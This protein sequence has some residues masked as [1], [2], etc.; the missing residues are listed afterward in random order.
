MPHAPP[1]AAR[2]PRAS[3]VETTNSTAGPGVKHSTVSSTTNA[4]QTCSVMRRRRV[5][6]SL[7]AAVERH[8]PNRR[9]VHV[10]ET[11]NI[12]SGRL[13]TVR[14]RAITERRATALGAEVMLDRVLVERVDGE[15]SLRRREAQLRARH[16]PEQVA[17]AAAVRA[18]A[19][20]DLADF[21]LDLVGRLPAV[22]AAFIEHRRSPRLRAG[23]PAR[24]GTG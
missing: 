4:I 16:E 7:A 13:E 10:L 18:I 24:A 14:R 17:F 2:C 20:D 8:A 1:N 11:A 12:D 6:R 9:E 15:T 19:F 21:A 3:A 5:D 22:A 23:Q